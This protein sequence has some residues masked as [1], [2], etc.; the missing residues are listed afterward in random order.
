MS[1]RA[2]RVLVPNIT[3]VVGVL[4]SSL[5]Y[6][7]EMG[8]GKTIQAIGLILAN[9]P[10]ERNYDTGA[11][12]KSL[13]KDDAIERSVDATT[14]SSMALLQ[15]YNTNTASIMAAASARSVF[16]SPAPAR[17]SFLVAADHS[18]AMEPL[19]LPPNKTAL[20][21]MK[22]GVLQTLVAKSG[23][24]PNGGKKDD[25]I[26][27]CLL[28]IQKRALTVSDFYHGNCAAIPTCDQPARRSNSTP[29]HHGNTQG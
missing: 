23:I 1:E 5:L 12:P 6:Y 9:P 19:I 21:K 13:K 2:T 17:A 24:A 18:A 11:R 7:I 10:R 25:L 22:V 14:T 15:D 16:V 28:A 26:V 8:L 27:A 20:R 3:L 29:Q 4:H